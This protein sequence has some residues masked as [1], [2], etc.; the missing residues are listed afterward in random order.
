[1]FGVLTF[2]SSFPAYVFQKEIEVCGITT[3]DKSK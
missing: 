2:T 3:T 1:M